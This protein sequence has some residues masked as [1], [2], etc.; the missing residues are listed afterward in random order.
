MLIDILVVWDLNDFFFFNIYGLI[1]NYI[2]SFGCL[3][4]FVGLGVFVGICDIG[5]EFLLDQDFEV[6]ISG[7]FGLNI[8]F[9]IIEVFGQVILCLKLIDGIVGVVG[10]GVGICFYL[11]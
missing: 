10:G 6:G 8:I 3:Y 7:N 5:G 9:G 1:E 4:Y 2:G 11:L